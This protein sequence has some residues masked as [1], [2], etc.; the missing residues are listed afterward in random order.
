MLSEPG[1]KHAGEAGR[2]RARCHEMLG[3][4]CQGGTRSLKA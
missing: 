4:V 2:S 1:P 3:N